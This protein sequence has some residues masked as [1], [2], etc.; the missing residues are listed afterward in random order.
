MPNLLLLTIRAP[1]LS[2]RRWP[3]PQ[4]HSPNRLLRL[5]SPVSSTSTQNTLGPGDRQVGISRDTFTPRLADQAR[6]ADR[7]IQDPFHLQTPVAF[8]EMH[9]YD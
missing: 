7:E 6:T 3:I 2:R 5:S 4:L 1:C 8:I 9:S